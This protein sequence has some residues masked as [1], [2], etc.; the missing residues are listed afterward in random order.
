MVI[1]FNLDARITYMN[2]AARAALLDEGDGVGRHFSEFIAS[3]YCRAYL[4]A[5]CQTADLCG[6]LGSRI[7]LRPVIVRRL[8]GRP[9]T[10]NM[11]IHECSTSEG[12]CF[13]AYLRP[14]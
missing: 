12:H 6:S 13:V 11:R 2:M 3:D 10:A 5:L 4:N 9:F 1:R 8:G 14:A 7:A